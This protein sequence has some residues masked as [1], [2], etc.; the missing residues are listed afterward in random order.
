M[1]E[2]VI[3]QAPR[4]SAGIRCLKYPQTGYTD[5]PGV[6]VPPLS[7]TK[8]AGQKQRGPLS[9]SKLLTRHA[10]IINFTRLSRPLLLHLYCWGENCV[11]SWAG[12]SK[13][14]FLLFCA[15]CPYTA[16]RSKLHVLLASYCLDEMSG[17]PWQFCGT[18]CMM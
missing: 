4:T 9:G 7:L 14:I 6:Q 12:W 3:L 1:C 17:G 5:D 11:C 10:N 13:V 18:T 8:T 16:L 15:G 2:R